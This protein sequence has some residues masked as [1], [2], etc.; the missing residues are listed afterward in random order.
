ML[1]LGLNLGYNF[2]QLR[3]YMI[4]KRPSRYL[5]LIYSDDDAMKDI[6]MH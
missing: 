1:L 6:S 5:Y 4:F 3:M 2:E